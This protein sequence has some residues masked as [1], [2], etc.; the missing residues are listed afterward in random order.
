VSLIFSVSERK[1]SIKKMTASTN[2]FGRAPWALV[3]EAEPF[4]NAYFI[5]KLC[6]LVK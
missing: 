6:R 1:I 5:T 3:I 4:R 2:P